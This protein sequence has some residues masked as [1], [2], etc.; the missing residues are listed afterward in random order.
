M[1]PKNFIALTHTM[2]LWWNS[3]MFNPMQRGPSSNNREGIFTIKYYFGWPVLQYKDGINMCC[4][5]VLVDR[6]V[7]EEVY[8]RGFLVFCQDMTKF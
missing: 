8:W 3:T 2:T 4:A 5:I 1:H 7:L 6:C